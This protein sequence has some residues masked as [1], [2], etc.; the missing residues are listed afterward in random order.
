MKAKRKKIVTLLVIYFMSVIVRVLLAVSYYE[1]Y[2]FYDELLHG[3]MAVS[4]ARLGHFEFRGI[5]N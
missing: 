1:V 3:K 5:S 2:T 4:L